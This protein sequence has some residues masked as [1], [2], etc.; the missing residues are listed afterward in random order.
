MS[1]VTV[2]ENN[3]KVS[4]NK[5]TNVV[6]VTSPGT[7]GPQGG[8]GTIES[9]T[10]TSSE[11]AVNSSGI[12]GSPTVA[13]TLGGTAEARTMAFAFGVP[14]GTSGV[15]Q[16]IATTGTDGIDVD[17]GGTMN[18]ASSAITLGINAQTLWNHILGADVTGNALIVSDGSNT[19]PIA[20]EGTITYTAV[21]NETTV[22]ESAGA[23]TIGLVDNPVV[24]G[25]TA[26]NVKVGVTGD[27]EIDTLSGNLT[28]DSA[29]GT[30][31]VDDNLTVAGNLTV[32]GTTTTIDSTITTIVDPIIV[33]Q[34]AVGGGALSSDTNKDIGLLMQYYTGSANKTAFLGYDDSAGKLAFIP[35]AT[36]S[37]EVISG[38]TGTMVV[39]IEGAVTGNASTATALATS[40]TIGMT[41]DVVWTSP[42]F[43]GSGNVTATATIQANSVTM[44][45]DTTGNY[46]ATVTAGTGLTST[47]ATSGESI[48]HSLSVDP[49][50]TQITSVGTIGTGVWQGSVIGYQYGG[51]G[52]DGKTGT[53]SNVLNVNC[54]LVTPDLGTPQSGVM[55]NVTGTASNLTAGTATN[56]TAV[57][58]DSTN[59]TVYPTFIDGATGAQGIETDTGL[60]YNPSTGLLTA[61]GFAGPITGAVTGNAATATALA[62]GR[63]VGM[64]G[65]VVWTSPTFDGSGNVT[66][67]ATIQAN[68]V[69][70]GTDTTGNY[71]ATV[72]AGT[73]LTSTGA[74]SGEGIAHSLSVDAA[75]TQI[76]SVGTIGAGTW[77]GTA[78]AD[79]YIASAATWTAKEDAGVAT[80][81]AIALG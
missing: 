79:A 27:N 10:A 45:T 60:T 71:T 54:T 1:S 51:T 38:S 20:L 74:T 52:T 59:E 68:S 26:G 21:A 32:S 66:A 28:L 29:G 2:T 61:A 41:G 44:G 81:M 25:V 65:D 55:T 34:T 77:Q 30:V 36:V 23:I 9:A 56:I 72:T 39:N 14:T 6:T 57:A 70:L 33:L 76:T 12:S 13:V 63:T 49:A 22:V 24:S 50:Q 58:N 73:G 7:I 46:V 35:D 69:A 80:A 78:V 67:S 15:I 11:V 53:G 40:R 43:D 18:T 47:G 48:A 17:S 5:T 8:S 19:S 62:T 16:S 4:V 37:S 3:N 42:S 75:Q 64:T 31:A